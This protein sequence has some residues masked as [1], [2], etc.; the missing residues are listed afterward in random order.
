[1]RKGGYRYQAKERQKRYSIGD[2]KPKHTVT[3]TLHDRYNSDQLSC[4]RVDIPTSQKRLQ[5]I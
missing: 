1:M 5:G 4:S 3:F 2:G